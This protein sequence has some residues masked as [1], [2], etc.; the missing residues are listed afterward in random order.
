MGSREANSGK[1]FALENILPP[2]ST[3]QWHRC[4]KTGLVSYRPAP[5]EVDIAGFVPVAALHSNVLSL[6]GV[7]NVS[8]RGLAL[9][10]GSDA[11][12][13]NA[14]SAEQ[15]AILNVSGGSQHVDIAGC[16]I[17][18]GSGAG[19][20]V[21]GGA[22]YVRV[23]SSWLHGLGGSGVSIG[24]TQADEQ[25]TRPQPSGP[26]P[27]QTGWFPHDVTV[28]NCVVAHVGGVFLTQPAGVRIAD[29]NRVAV[30]GCDIGFSTYAGI[31][32]RLKATFNGHTF[33]RNHVHDY[34]GLLSDLGGVYI[35]GSCQQHNALCP[36]ANT[37]IDSNIIRR[38]TFFAHG[39]NGIYVDGGP[40]SLSAWIAVCPPCSCE[41]P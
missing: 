30:R 37:S 21:N 25:N 3:G 28:E 41:R 39:G 36:E 4:A 5:G 33:E 23:R 29:A 1:R 27:N 32:A 12:D 9:L 6:V 31:V 17:S 10:Y 14:P 13:R 26:Q 16:E 15:P 8:I 38:S 2:P 11:N 7:R 18:C 40:S 24:P 20:G 34:G 35:S 22:A 19:V